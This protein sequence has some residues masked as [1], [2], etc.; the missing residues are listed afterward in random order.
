M[1]VKHSIFIIRQHNTDSI[2]IECSVLE[3]AVSRRS[4]REESS[5]GRREG[6][7]RECG[8]DGVKREEESRIAFEKTYFRE[9][10]ADGDRGGSGMKR[11]SGMWMY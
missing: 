6:K 5:V 4:G 11:G 9:D 1:L 2:N 8:R 7:E 3:E 10:K